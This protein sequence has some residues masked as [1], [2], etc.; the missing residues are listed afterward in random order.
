MP[1]CLLH[2]NAIL[3]QIILTMKTHIIFLYNNV[4]TKLAFH[5]NET[6][7]DKLSIIYN[8]LSIVVI[9][10]YAKLHKIWSFLHVVEQTRAQKSPP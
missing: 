1:L 3:T 4:T 7:K 6:S 9:Q 5:S 2:I 10:V 8:W